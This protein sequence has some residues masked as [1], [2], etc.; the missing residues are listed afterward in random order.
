M[1]FLQKNSVVVFAVTSALFGLSMGI[2]QI[3]EVYTYDLPAQVVTR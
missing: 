3:Y 2:E 1:R